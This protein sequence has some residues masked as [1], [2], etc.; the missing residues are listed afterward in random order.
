MIERGHARLKEPLH[1]YDTVLKSLLSGSQNSIFQSITGA[2]SGQWLN[3]ELPAVSQTRVDLLFQTYATELAGQRLI[4]MELQSTNDALLPLRMAEYSLRIYRNYKQFPEQYVLYVGS[5][6]MSMPNELA[7]PNHV[8]RYTV[9]DI[10]NW[11]A[12]ALLESP[13]AADAVLAILARYGDA[14]ETIRRI[15]ARIAKLGDKT[16]VSAA[17]SKLTILAG[18]RKLGETVRKE[19]QS[20]PILDDIMDHDLLGPAIRQGLEKGRQEGRQE[21]RNEEALAFLSV[22][23]TRRFGTVPAE[24]RERL[25]KMSTSELEEVGQRLFEVAS[26]DELFGHA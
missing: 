12:D 5:D 4:A 11:S 13:F 3:V 2:G 23:M 6:V 16:E 10:R 25:A 18:I 20:M 24:V 9:I 17:F 19:A 1:H 21:G 7:G 8:C 14:P 22:L 15:L 26:I